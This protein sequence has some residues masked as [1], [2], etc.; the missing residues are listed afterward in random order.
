[1]NARNN[2]AIEAVKAAACLDEQPVDLHDL[3]RQQSQGG[4]DKPVNLEQCEASSMAA[5]L[6]GLVAVTAVLQAG[7]DGDCL[8]LSNW[9]KG[10][11]LD[12]VHELAVNTQYTL[13]A[14]NSRAEKELANKGGAHGL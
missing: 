5:S 1:M 10:G 13:E 12:A 4:Y 6:R 9:F 7:I 11:L 14:A 8:T 3:Y 2:A